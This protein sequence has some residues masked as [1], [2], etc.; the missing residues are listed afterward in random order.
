M[1]T[2]VY[3]DGKMVNKKTG[4]PM[5]KP[6]YVF[7]PTPQVTR[8]MPDYQSP[9]DGSPITSRHARRE[10][11]KKNGCVPYEE[12][13]S[14]TKGRVKNPKFARNGLKLVETD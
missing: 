4:E 5:E 12:S 9:I 10:D 8:L 3:R 7:F 2:Y 11:L 6:D 14:P 13:M 1:T